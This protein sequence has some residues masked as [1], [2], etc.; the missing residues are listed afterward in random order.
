MCAEGAEEAGIGSGGEDKDS[1]VRTQERS[2]RRPE[3][4]GGQESSGR[5]RVV[6]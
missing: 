1:G 3:D 6:G 5:R 2:R 4:G